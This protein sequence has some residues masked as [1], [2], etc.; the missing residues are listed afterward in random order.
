MLRRQRDHVRRRC[1]SLVRIGAT[2][3]KQ[4]VLRLCLGYEDPNHHEELCRHRLLTLFL[5]KTT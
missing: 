3:I 5:T 1:C 2:L 4:R